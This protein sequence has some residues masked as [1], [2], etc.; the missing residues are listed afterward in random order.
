MWELRAQR[1]RHARDR[2]RVARAQPWLAMA[3]G[4][5]QQRRG[6]GRDPCFPAQQAQP[7]ALWPQQSH[8]LG[9]RE[10]SPRRE[11]WKPRLR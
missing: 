9:R 11:T 5:A 2:R 7:T 1:P 10:P 6:N 8:L 4:W 3:W